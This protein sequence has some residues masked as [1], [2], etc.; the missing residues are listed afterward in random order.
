ME[1][2]NIAQI[3]SIYSEL[4]GYLL[5]S[6]EPTKDHPLGGFIG[7]AQLWSKFNMTLD[8]LNILTNNRYSTFKLNPNSSRSQTHP[9]LGINYY[10]SSLAGLIFKLHEDYFP[11]YPPRILVSE[12]GKIVFNQNIHKEQSISLNIFKE[13]IDEKIPLY[14]EGSKQRSFLERLKGY[15]QTTNNAYDI[16]RNTISLARKFGLSFDDILKIFS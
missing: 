10:R 7:D 11:D 12:S 14:E 2:T 13:Q 6:P 8:N 16:I 5:T 9:I 15:I 3:K 4:Q 1:T